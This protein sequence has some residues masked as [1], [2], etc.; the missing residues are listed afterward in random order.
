MLAARYIAL[1]DSLSIDVY[2][3]EDAA[4]R[5]PGRASTDRLGA[6]SL[7]VRNDDP[8]WPEFRGRDLLTFT[9]S[10]RFDDETADGATTHNLLM[11]V[12]RI[13]RSDEPTL[14]TITAGGNDLLGFL[15][16][17]IASPAREIAGR[18]RAAVARV[19]E[20][21][22]N[23]TMLLGTVYDPS[24]GTKRLPG[25]PRPLEREAAWL[26]EYN[27]LVRRLASSDPRLRLADIHRHFLGHGL[28]VPVDEQWYLRESII[29]PNARGASEVR[30][31]WLEAI[32]R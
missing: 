32:G 16:T 5:Y 4:L 31:V 14:V 13:H 30:R 6:A 17:N 8:F 1:G 23:T 29:E 28:T 18:L 3:A 10:L 25:F 19:L 21:R 7:F 24:D 26:D 22:P 27:D 15:G 12:E 11:Q 20:L 2:P 9:P